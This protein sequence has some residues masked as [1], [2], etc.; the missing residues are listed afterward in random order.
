MSR[1]YSTQ[2]PIQGQNTRN[3]ASNGPGYNLD[4]SADAVRF[5]IDNGLLNIEIR[6]DYLH[7]VLWLLM[8]KGLA[9]EREDEAV[10]MARE[11]VSPA[12]NYRKESFDSDLLSF[13]PDRKTRTGTWINLAKENGWNP[14]NLTKE[15]R[16]NRWYFQYA[17]A[18]CGVPS[19]YLTGH[20]GYETP[21]DARVLP[22]G[23][24]LLPL[25]NF[26]NDGAGF[27]I[28]KR[29]PN[30]DVW[31]KGF[32][33]GTAASGAFWANLRPFG[34][35]KERGCESFLEQTPRPDWEAEDI[36]HV[37][38]KTTTV[39]LTESPAKCLAIM[40]AFSL[41]GR[42]DLIE[43]QAMA[44]FS[45]MTAGNMGKVA[46]GI[47]ERRPD[48]QLIVV[49]DREE[50]GAG[51][52]AAAQVCRMFE[53]ARVVD[54]GTGD[55]DDYYRLHGSA[56]TCALI[57]S[58]RTMTPDEIEVALQ[59]RG[60]DADNVADFAEA[61]RKRQG[62]ASG[63]GGGQSK[64]K[65]GAAGYSGIWRV[66]EEMEAIDGLEIFF[67]TFQQKPY[68]RWGEGQELRVIDDDFAFDTAMKC[69]EAF[70]GVSLPVVRE[71]IR[72]FASARRYDSAQQWLDGLKWDGTPRV[73]RF[74]SDYLET[75]DTP[76]TKEVGCY[77]WTALAGR[78][79]EPGVKAD[80]VPLLIGEQGCS[81]SEAT[82]SIAPSE[83]QYAGLDFGTS[84]AENIRKLVSGR[85]VVELDELKGLS[86]RAVEHVK[87]FLSTRTD[88]HRPL[89]AASYVQVP[90]RWVAV[91]TTNDRS[92]LKDATGHRRWL[93][94]QIVGNCS[95]EKIR[96]D[97]DQLW[98]EGAALFRQHGV[99]FYQ[100]EKLAKFE[101][102]KFEFLDEWTEV[103]ERYCHL[104]PFVTGLEV[105]T[106]REGLGFEVSQVTMQVTKRI[107]GILQR[108][109]Y[110]AGKAP[111]GE[112]GKR[113]NGYRL[114]AHGTL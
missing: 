38:Y 1:K 5:L 106:S 78:I 14:P 82:R 40:A 2:D 96:Q 107:A 99:M 6:D 20:K 27:W 13:N 16:L 91:A 113:I 46:R 75:E 81:K 66:L 28:A 57:D 67:D 59:R 109:G 62:R 60:V 71:A 83:D 64:P 69:E 25:T 23:A 70:D 49:A 55:I 39:I 44:L 15:E 9:E 100:A 95:P 92:C 43:S 56:A 85:C 93:P 73:A 42:E 11:L 108:L 35:D 17:N 41:E 18:S 29:E 45:T 111:S 68:F 12:K 26:D 65:K 97:R 22:D 36:K 48:I 88:D 50:S 3:T 101:H 102:G 47:K 58:A 51:I 86:E 72:R 19:P 21:R 112:R 79:I 76:Y 80:M 61:R 34:Y 52:R 74:C 10:E 24:T 33:S 84:D 53:D 114:E 32:V 77:L 98:A 104:K 87:S 8:S 103:V 4:Q 110:R 90:R 63:A 37:V 89:Y 7:G 30:S 105:A 31:F 54:P 94:V